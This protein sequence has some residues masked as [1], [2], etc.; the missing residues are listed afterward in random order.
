[1]NHQLKKYIP[2]NILDGEA[3]KELDKI[4]EIE[5]DVDREKLVYKT[6]IHT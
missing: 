6:N 2:E 5:K 4:S 3:K 1:M